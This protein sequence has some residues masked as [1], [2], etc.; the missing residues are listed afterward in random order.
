MRP[1]ICAC[2]LDAFA[3]LPKFLHAQ[4]R[5]VHLVWLNEFQFVKVEAIVISFDEETNRTTEG[6][7][8]GRIQIESRQIIQSAKPHHRIARLRST[9][10][11]GVVF[12]SICDDL[13]ACADVFSGRL[14]H[15]CHQRDSVRASGAVLSVVGD[16]ETVMRI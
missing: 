5:V 9:S 4:H 8:A 14:G 1:L 7:P 13:E 16:A 11:V 6:S 10:W 2:K 3:K 15:R 12:D